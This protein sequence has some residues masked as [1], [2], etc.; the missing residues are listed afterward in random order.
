M[1]ITNERI[2]IPFL[3]LLHRIKHDLM[4]YGDRFTE[5]DAD[6][7]LEAAPIAKG[8]GTGFACTGETMIDYPSFCKLLGGFRKT[9]NN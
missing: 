6:I 3:S 7:A 9:P 8:T 2:H 1:I 5:R 4:C